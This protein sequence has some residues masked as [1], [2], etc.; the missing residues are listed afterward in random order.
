M[1]RPRARLLIGIVMAL[2]GVAARAADIP[3]VVFEGF[4]LEE[5]TGA[6]SVAAALRRSGA[7]SD[8][9]DHDGLPPLSVAVRGP[10][11]RA[12]PALTPLAAE[13]RSRID[14]FD[15]AAGVRGD[16]TAVS[17][18]RADWTGRIGLASEHAAGSER[19]ELRT[20]V[21]RRAEAGVVGVEVGP[22]IERRLGRGMLF[23]IDGK[24]EAQTLRDLESGWW[25]LPG[26]AAIDATVGVTARTG[27]VR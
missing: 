11:G 13:V 26:A 15:V 24:A 6:N 5:F 2:A 17:E 22:R 7:L 19:I 27:L 3:P 1:T 21:G 20:M 23:F 8:R 25:G 16:P 10:S 14:Q 9:P 4:G 18:G 12:D